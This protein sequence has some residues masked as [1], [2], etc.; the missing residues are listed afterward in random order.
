MQRRMSVRVWTS[1]HERVQQRDG[2]MCNDSRNETEYKFHDIVIVKAV[3]R[4]LNHPPE[5]RLL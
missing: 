1:T 2:V 3:G 5:K 4:N